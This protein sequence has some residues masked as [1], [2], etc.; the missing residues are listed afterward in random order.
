[1][2]SRP[3]PIHVRML[4]AF[5]IQQLY[6]NMNRLLPPRVES[7]EHICFSTT[8]ARL[9]TRLIALHYGRWFSDVS[10]LSTALA[11][12][13]SKASYRCQY[14]GTSRLKTATIW[15]QQGGILR[16][17]AAKPPMMKALAPRIQQA[18]KTIRRVL[19]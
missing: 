2:C 15:L 14:T 1:M 6:C 12:L 13:P 3:F 17:L 10:G 19:Q 4:I 5:A 18:R 9:G 7:S 16:R 8:P 11:T